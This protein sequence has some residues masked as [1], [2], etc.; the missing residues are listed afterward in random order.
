MDHN[1]NQRRIPL[2]SQGK[3]TADMSVTLYIDEHRGRGSRP[4]TSGGVFE[5]VDRPGHEQRYGRPCQTSLDDPVTP[6]AHGLVHAAYR[7]YHAGAHLRLRPDDVWLGILAQLGVY[8]STHPEARRQL[9]ARDEGEQPITV[10]AAD[11]PRQ[12]TD[13]LARRAQDPLLPVWALPDFSTTTPVDR[14]AAAVLLLGTAGPALATADALRASS[15]SSPT[16]AALGEARGTTLAAALFAGPAEEYADSLNSGLTAVTLTGRASDYRDML[17]RLPPS[18]TAQLLARLTRPVVQHMV[19]S[20]EEGA[21][22]RV[23]AFWRHM[24][25]ASELRSGRTYLSGWIAAFC[26]VSAGEGRLSGYADADAYV[27]GGVRY[28][29]V[30]TLGVP[31]GAAAVPVVVEEEEEG[32]KAEGTVVAGLMAVRATRQERTGGAEEIIEPVSGW[33]IYVNKE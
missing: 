32:D 11:L 5:A 18:D 22:P 30:H 6:S 3:A 29:G 28:P 15:S 33:S 16:A 14:A 12:M 20:L 19:F 25:R 21:T 4:G 24:V 27:L 17:R 7:A 10:R 8:L 13:L 2:R 26:C 23:L 1:K 31:P 9:L